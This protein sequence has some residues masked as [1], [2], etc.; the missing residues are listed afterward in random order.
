[1][2]SSYESVPA[3]EGHEI[4]S[5]HSTLKNRPD[6]YSPLTGS[7]LKQKREKAIPVTGLGGP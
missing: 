6:V 4:M 3:L 1:M 5:D 7:V 2:Y